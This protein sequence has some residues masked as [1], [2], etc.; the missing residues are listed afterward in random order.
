[1]V[2]VEYRVQVVLEVVTGRK[3]TG[4]EVERGQRDARLISQDRFLVD[5]SRDS[6][7]SMAVVTI[8]CVFALS[9]AV[10]KELLEDTGNEYQPSTGR[11]PTTNR[12]YVHS[13][14]SGPPSP[15]N[16]LPWLEDSQS[17]NK[18][19]TRSSASFP[20]SDVKSQ[21]PLNGII[22]GKNSQYPV[23]PV[24][25]SSTGPAINPTDKARPPM[26]VHVV[27]N[28]TPICSGD[29]SCRDVPGHAADMPSKELIR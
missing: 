13:S 22:P 3:A 4:K 21:G 28:S 20:G 6:Q 11:D 29:I 18:F 5:A 26:K 14:P 24:L 10:H 19:I 7:S 16:H 2:E 27:E 23:G 17:V 25:D 8:A 9:M 15:V 12:H 1:M